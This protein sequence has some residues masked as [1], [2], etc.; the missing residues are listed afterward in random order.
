MN[1]KIVQ[2]TL[3]YAFDMN[4]GFGRNLKYV[5]AAAAFVLGFAAFLESRAL[6]QGYVISGLVAAVAC[7]IVIAA[8]N[9]IARSLNVDRLTFAPLVELITAL[10]P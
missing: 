4:N 2:N 9:R 6:E 1:S 10:L 3:I 8:F 5:A 7:A